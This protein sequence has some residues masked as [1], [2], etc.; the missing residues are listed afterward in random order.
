MKRS[1]R[2]VLTSFALAGLA[3]GVQV[4]AAGATPASDGAV[5]VRAGHFPK[6]AHRPAKKPHR[7]VKKQRPASG[8]VRVGGV[9]VSHTRRTVTV[10]ASSLSVGRRRAANKRVTVR[11]VVR[12]RSATP[13]AGNAASF[14]ASLKDGYRIN[15]AGNGLM[16]DNVISLHR[17]RSEDHQA[18]AATAWF[19]TVT[20]IDAANGSSTVQLSED[21]CGEETEE[22]GNQ[23]NTVTVDF[24]TAT[25]TVD[26]SPGDLA[27]GQLVVVLGEASNLTVLAETVYA[28]TSAA[29]SVRGEISAVD[30]TLVTVGE[31]DDREGDGDDDGESAV[32]IDLGSG[33]AAI[34]LIL[35]GNPGATADQLRR[36][37]KILV[38][39]TQPDGV[40][41]VPALAVAFNEHDTGPVGDN[42][43]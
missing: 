14:D 39:G 1:T 38:V 18:A 19:G 25:I 2:I 4:G 32:T 8:K 9:V 6:K 29:A 40:T 12:R 43:D 33:S 17:L 34:P 20:S 7:P 42:E 26:G 35:N 5:A 27:V 36:G 10:F 16:R 37:D 21:A 23:N 13:N 30:G 11:L 41:F 28:F 24:S 15:L 22:H 31:Q 3:A